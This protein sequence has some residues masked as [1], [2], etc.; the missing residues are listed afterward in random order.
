[1][2][3]LI[4]WMGNSR[5]KVKNFPVSTRREAGYQL[6]RVQQGLLPSDWKPM[7]RIG[8]GV[9]EIRLH[10]LHEHRV[11]YVTKFEESIYVL[12]AFEKKT[13]KTAQRDIEVARQA[14][15]KIL[16]LRGGK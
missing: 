9:A 11:I 15:K 7:P 5:V 14:F 2:G 1:M 12:H 10:E 16:N 8:S 3:K 13:G 4:T 6:Y